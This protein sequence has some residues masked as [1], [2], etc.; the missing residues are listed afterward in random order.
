MSRLERGPSSLLVR[1]IAWPILPSTPN[2][3][4]LVCVSLKDAA[5]KLVSRSVYPIWISSERGKLVNDVATRRD[6]GPWL[7]ELKKAPTKLR[8]RPISKKAKFSGADY[9]PAGT[10]HC[11]KVIV[12]VANIGDK[13]AFHTGIE[14]TNA[15]CRY[16]CD[17][18]YFMLMPGETKRVK[19]EIDRS[20]QPFYDFVRPELVQP[21]GAELKLA[22][23]AWNAPADVCT[24][25]VVGPQT[26]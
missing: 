19:I 22:A 12:E 5:G 24:I 25:A 4:A 15:D 17:D 13:P 11:A 26:R 23:S 20:L 3:T 6:H 16:L 9:L 2:Q 10:Q 14:I 21:V 8:I 7:T 18:N 1:T